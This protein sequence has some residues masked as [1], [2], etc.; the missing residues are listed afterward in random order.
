MEQPLQKRL[1]LQ[2]RSHKRCVVVYDTQTHVQPWTSQ[3]CGDLSRLLAK[4]P[5]C[6]P[7][8]KTVCLQVCHAVHCTSDMLR[9][10]ARQVLALV[11]SKLPPC[12]A[13]QLQCVSRYAPLCLLFAS[14]PRSCRSVGRV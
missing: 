12:E 1:T 3:S 6:L 4:R 2:L 10:P 14:P 11:V 5:K 8:F 9:L 7:G 13:V